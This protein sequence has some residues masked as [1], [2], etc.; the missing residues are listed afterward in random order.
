MRP[1]RVICIVVVC[2]AVF[3]AIL[4]IHSPPVQTLTGLLRA[5]YGAV[6]RPVFRA[7]FGHD[8]DISFHNQLFFEREKGDGFLCESR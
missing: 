8:P 7:C 5:C 3:C 2:Y 6:F 4:A 1:R